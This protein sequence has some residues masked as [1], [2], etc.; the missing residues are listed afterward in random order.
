MESTA[1]IVFICRRKVLNQHTLATIATGMKILTKD[2]YFDIFGRLTF[3]APKSTK[4]L[5]QNELSTS[6]KKVAIK[7][8]KNNRVRK[9]TLMYVN[10][11]QKLYKRI[12]AITSWLLEEPG[13]NQEKALKVQSIGFFFDWFLNWQSKTKMN[14]Q[15]IRSL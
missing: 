6:G 1:K 14:K 3:R 10:M 11:R 15:K 7:T 9:L 4:Q 5:Y 2:Y 12:Q 13:K 8:N